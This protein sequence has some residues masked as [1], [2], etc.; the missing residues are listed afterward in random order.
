VTVRDK[1]TNSKEAPM[2]YAGTAISIRQGFKEV[3]LPA[4][5]AGLSGA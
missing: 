2:R 5:T 1:T 4:Y 3:K